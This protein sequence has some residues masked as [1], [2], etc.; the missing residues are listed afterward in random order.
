[1]TMEPPPDSE[2]GTFYVENTSRVGHHKLVGEIIRMEAITVRKLLLTITTIKNHE[3][4]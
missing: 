1:M 2:K 3:L 4:K